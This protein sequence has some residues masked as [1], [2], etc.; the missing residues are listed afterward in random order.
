ME[1]SKT[2]DCQLALV[3]HDQRL[4]RQRSQQPAGDQRRGVRGSVMTYTS[5]ANGR[6]ILK[7]QV[8]NATTTPLFC[9]YKGLRTG[10]LICS[11][12]RDDAL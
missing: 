11:S 10:L 9:S 4:F 3:N 1:G 2:G 7:H 12:I 5:H 6:G 8:C